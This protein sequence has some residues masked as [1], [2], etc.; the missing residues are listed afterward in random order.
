[1]ARQSNSK[2]TADTGRWLARKVRNPHNRLDAIFC[3]FT[4]RF[5]GAAGHE[6]RWC[7]WLHTCTLC[8][9][10]DWSCDIKRSL[11]RTLIPLALLATDRMIEALFC[12]ALSVM[13]SRIVRLAVHWSNCELFERY[14]AYL[15]RNEQLSNK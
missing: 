5:H 14:F 10:T 4:G 2:E 11:L 3:S 8:D 12:V 1:M 9:G 6:G 15:C 7:G 13:V